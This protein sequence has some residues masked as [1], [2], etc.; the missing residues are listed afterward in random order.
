MEGCAVAF[1]DSSSLK[2]HKRTHTVEKQYVCDC[3][4]CNAAF[5]TSSSLTRHERMHP[6]RMHPKRLRDEML[7]TLIEIV[8]LEE[9]RAKRKQSQEIEE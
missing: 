3:D 4:G 1:G 6:K 9:S 2:V 8:E 7:P 5:A